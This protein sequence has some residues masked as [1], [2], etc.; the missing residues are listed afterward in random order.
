MKIQ[1][2]YDTYK[3]MPQLREHM[4]RVAAVAATVCDNFDE[5]LPKENIIEA[6]L[7][8]DMGNIVKFDLEYTKNYFP[9]FFA[10]QGFEYWQGI[11]KEFIEK[12][13][14]DDHLATFAIVKELG[15]DGKTFELVEAITTKMI[16]KSD[17]SLN[18]DILICKYVDFR[19]GP[20][21]VLGL[22]ERVTEW[23]NRDKR[24]SEEYAENSYNLFTQIEKQIFSK[25]KIQPEDITDETIQPI[26]SELQNFVLK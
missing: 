6:C 10:Q 5:P 25:C 22:R 13:G 7:L 9:E 17:S 24:I 3:I 11:Q 23:K 12:Y 18:A 19:V 14:T 26:I 1:E 4:L 21:G 16:E 2:I 8:H 15:I 20:K